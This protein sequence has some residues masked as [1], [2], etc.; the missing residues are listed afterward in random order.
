MS[1]D[2]AKRLRDH[3]TLRGG[4]AKNEDGEVILQNG[5][6]SMMLEAATEIDRLNMIVHVARKVFGDNPKIPIKNLVDT[7]REYDGQ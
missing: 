1:A 5:A 7:I 4:V 3:V 6:W 2:I